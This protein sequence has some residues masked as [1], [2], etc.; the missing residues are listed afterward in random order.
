MTLRLERAKQKSS[1]QMD[2]YSRLQEDIGLCEDLFCMPEDAEIEGCFDRA[3]IDDLNK[4]LEIWTDEEDGELFDANFVWRTEELLARLPFE[5]ALQCKE[6][7]DLG[8]AQKCLDSKWRSN[9]S[10][11]MTMSA[12]EQ[13]EAHRLFEYMCYFVIN[14]REELLYDIESRLFSNE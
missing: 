4:L 8:L 2:L 6:P 13:I 1:Q 9:P 10:L 5:K 11:I 3:L 14:V 12:A 7:V